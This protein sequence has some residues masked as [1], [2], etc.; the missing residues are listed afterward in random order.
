MNAKVML[1]QIAVR[2]AARDP[3]RADVYTANAAK[4]KADIDLLDMELARDLAPLKTQ[5]YI[6]FHDA[7]QYLE[8]HYGLAPVGSITTNPDVPPSGKRLADLRRKVQGLGAVCVFAEP[9]FDAKVVAA[10]IE[11]TAARRGVLDPE[12]TTLAAGPEFYPTMMR[13]L[14]LNLKRC[15]SGAG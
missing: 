12:G 11:G 1:D 5:P 13:Q 8:A 3:V 15:L 10:V 2:L 9:N 4:A 14:V 7:L 6:V